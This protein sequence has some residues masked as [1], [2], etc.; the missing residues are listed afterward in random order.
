MARP[1]ALISRAPPPAGKPAPH[2]PAPPQACG[3]G[4]GSAVLG[5]DSA[6][7][8]PRRLSPSGDMDPSRAIQ[9][10]ISSLR[11]AG[12]RR[13]PRR[14]HGVCGP[15]CDLCLDAV[16]T[17]SGPES[18]AQGAALGVGELE[19]Q[20]ARPMTHRACSWVRGPPEA[21]W[22]GS[23]H[24]PVAPRPRSP[25]PCS[26]SGGG[27]AA[28]AAAGGGS[29]GGSW[30]LLAVGSALSP[31]ALCRVPA[32]LVGLPPPASE[33]ARPGPGITG[34]SAR[35]WPGQVHTAVLC[36]GMGVLGAAK[37]A[38]WLPWDRRGL[39]WGG[40]GRPVCPPWALPFAESAAADTVWGDEQKGPFSQPWD[41]RG[42]GGALGLGPRGVRWD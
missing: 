26:V 38:D 30:L 12:P 9:Q 41:L 19:P 27:A 7:R 32:Q 11:G 42:R 24:S 35:R 1:C 31:P 10:E 6:W 15:S 17:G 18:A 2:L 28:A 37:G 40:G 33:G 13:G 22:E 36:S 29:G 3:S 25:Q 21:G 14:E 23:S 34:E 16:P 5:L 4:L 8:R 39:E 20:E